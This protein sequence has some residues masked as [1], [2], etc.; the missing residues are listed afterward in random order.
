MLIRAAEPDDAM[1]VARVHVRSWQAGYR[2]LLPADYLDRLRPQDRAQRYTFESRDGRYPRTYVA[3]ER[4]QIC[5]FATIAPA[6][7]P[8]VPEHGELCALYVDPEWWRRGVGSALAKEARGQLYESGFRQALAWVL[9]G[10]ERADRFYR[11]DGWIPDGLCRS[12]SAWG[13]TVDEIRYRRALNARG[14]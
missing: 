12:A 2:E 4:D 9:S 5:A 7:D 8:D 10:N 13:I 3:L 14:S 11:T 6:G 1:A